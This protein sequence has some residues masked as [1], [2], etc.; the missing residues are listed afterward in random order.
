MSRDNTAVIVL[1]DFRVHELPYVPQGYINRIDAGVWKEFTDQI[2]T[3]IN[4]TFCQSHDIASTTSLRCRLYFGYWI[5]APLTCVFAFCAYYFLMVGSV[6][7]TILLVT[8]AL[9]AILAFICLIGSIYS[10]TKCKSLMKEYFNATH[11]DLNK[12]FLYMNQRYNNLIYFSSA[13]STHK[14]TG[15]VQLGIYILHV[16]LL[17]TLY[18][19]F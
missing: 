14:N 4:N 16:F 11:N 13:R 6:A 19:I 7:S 5:C 18:N 9:L 15:K 10:A 1:K 2:E 17:Y 8:G 12:I 3:N